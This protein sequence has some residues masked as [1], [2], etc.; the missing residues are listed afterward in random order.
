MSQMRAGL[1]GI[2]VYN[3]WDLRQWR[4]LLSDVMPY[5]LHS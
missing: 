2:C 5:S 3:I 4:E 1:V